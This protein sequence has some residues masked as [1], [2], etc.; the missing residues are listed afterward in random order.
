MT[1]K[2]YPICIVSYSTRQYSHARDFA[3]ISRRWHGWLVPW[4]V[5]DAELPAWEPY[6]PSQ[7]EE[8]PRV[9]SDGGDFLVS[10]IQWLLY[11][12]ANCCW[13]AGRASVVSS[14]GHC[15]CVVGLLLYDSPVGNFVIGRAIP[16]Y[17]GCWSIAVRWWH[18]LSKG[19]CAPVAVAI[20]EIISCC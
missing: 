18:S 8:A 2:L 11:M 7:A 16:C 15:H 1:I 13:M 10:E 5:V 12:Y 17:G 4:S 9:W 19:C 3:G 6:V 14:P 20:R